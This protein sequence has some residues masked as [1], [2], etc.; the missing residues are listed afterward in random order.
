MLLAAT[1]GHRVFARLLDAQ[2]RVAG[3]MRTPCGTPLFSRS[4]VQ[5]RRADA[6]RRTL[7]F[8]ITAPT[9][10]SIRTPFFFLPSRSA[11]HAVRPAPHEAMRNTA[12]AIQPMK[13]HRCYPSMPFVRVCLQTAAFRATQQASSSPLTSPHSSTCAHLN[14]LSPSL[15]QL[16]MLLLALFYADVN[17]E[18]Q[19]VPALIILLQ[20]FITATHAVNPFRQPPFDTNG[21]NGTVGN[22]CHA[23]SVRPAPALQHDA[24]YSTMLYE[25]MWNPHVHEKHF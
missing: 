23:S 9:A 19:K 13:R 24:R 7:A 18:T 15:L 10:S 2:R 12:A 25:C 4:L 21:T 5:T 1:D 3:A 8:A 22:A 14:S 17:G 16:S 20:S 6:Q 11:V